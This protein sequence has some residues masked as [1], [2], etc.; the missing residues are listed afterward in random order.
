MASD[1]QV[2]REAQCA[3]ALYD[4]I[5]RQGATGVMALCVVAACGG[6]L[7]ETE[8]RKAVDSMAAS[9]LFSPPPGA[10]VVETRRDVCGGGS[11]APLVERLFAG[12]LRDPEAIYRQRLLADGWLDVRD[13][14]AGG[15]GAV[16]ADR[17]VHVQASEGGWTVTMQQGTAI[18]S[19][20]DLSRGEVVTKGS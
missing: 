5:D 20:D 18:A 15:V 6:G 13:V 3:G 11:V 16:M 1:G 12:T 9:S 7:S 19:C 8:A 2:R 4:S 14:P 17:A 10:T